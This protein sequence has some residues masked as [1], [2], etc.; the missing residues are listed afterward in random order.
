ME[1]NSENEQAKLLISGFMSMKVRHIGAKG[2][3]IIL[4]LPACDVEAVGRQMSRWTWK[5]GCGQSQVRIELC[6]QYRGHSSE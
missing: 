5:I 1:Y 4:V 6:G 3:R 2:A